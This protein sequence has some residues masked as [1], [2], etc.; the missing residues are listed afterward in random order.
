L[1]VVLDPTAGTVKFAVVVVKALTPAA[2]V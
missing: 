2:P 1:T